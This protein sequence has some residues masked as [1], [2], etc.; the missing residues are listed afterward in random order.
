MDFF[1]AI[2]KDSELALNWDQV[3]LRVEEKINSFHLDVLTFL[4]QGLSCS[5][6]ELKAVL[7]PSGEKERQKGTKQGLNAE[8][9]A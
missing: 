7:Y 3:T 2:F 5:N 6:V 9:L 1:S 8:K 4:A